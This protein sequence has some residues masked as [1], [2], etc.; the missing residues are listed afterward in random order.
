MESK[1]KMH[2]KE[3]SPE[4][5]VQNIINKLYKLNIK[6][7][8]RW[9]ID[10]T[11]GTHSLRVNFFGTSIGSNGKGIDK[12]YARASAYAELLERYQ[13]NLLCDT[14]KDIRQKCHKKYGFSIAPDEKY[15]D[16]KEIILQ[17]SSFIDYYFSIRNMKNCSLE[18]KMNKFEEVNISNENGKY[19][20]LPF[21]SFKNKKIY[22]LPY[23]CY[24]KY[25]GSNGMASGNTSYEALVQAL[26]EIYERVAQRRIL[27]EH[28][29]LPEIPEEYIKKY[30]YIHS[31]YVKLKENKDYTI[32]LLDCSFEGKY[33]VA[34]LLLAKKNT[35][36]FGI[37]LGCHPEYGVAMERTFTEASQGNKVYEYYDRSNFDF[38]NKTVDFDSNIINTYKY[39][40]G[41]FP[42]QI[43]GD[44]PSYRYVE[45]SDVSSF[46]NEDL[47]KHWISKI[48]DEDRDVLIRDSSYLGFPTYQVIVPW[49][50]ETL[51]LDDDEIRALNTYSYMSKI[52]KK[53][54]LIN[55]S[56]TKYIIGCL[57]HFSNDL[58]NNSLRSHYNVKIPIKL[59]FEEIGCE[60][61]YFAAMC[62]VINEEYGKAY[63]KV[64]MMETVAL[65]RNVSDELLF[66][67]RAIA[68][69]LSGMNELNDSDFV[70]KYVRQLYDD[71]TCNYISQIFSN[72]SDVIINQYPSEQDIYNWNKDSY[73]KKEITYKLREQQ[74]ISN[75]DQMNLSNLV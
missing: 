58:M 36:R 34:G 70:M 33:P 49:V 37:K 59:P 14:S 52:V 3:I 50:S 29:T 72:T 54:H 20:C 57:N 41:Q 17:N 74:Q 51:Q 26:S 48:I 30:P 66:K 4:Q 67:I 47:L 7:S 24:T 8:E 9:R 55:K 5:T 1:H 42:Y 15:M 12:L 61:I 53:P 11:I 13:N 62:D 27:K 38:Y 21:Y 23:S 68:C 31:M 63:D 64:H 45:P 56:N 18:E 25:Y 40:K 39:G 65:L 2:Y 6:V 69:Y 22:Y 19:L 73:M 32:K 43:F 10:D 71:S 28:P 16:S 44:K 46:T 60:C 75:I 35:N